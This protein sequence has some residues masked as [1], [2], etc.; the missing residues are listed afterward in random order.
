MASSSR[1]LSAPCVEQTKVAAQQV[2]LEIFRLREEF[3]HFQGIDDNAR[4]GKA[5]T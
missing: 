3:R 5:E 1:V 4:S 2:R